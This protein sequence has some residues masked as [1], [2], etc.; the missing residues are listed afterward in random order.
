MISL[1]DLPLGPSPPPGL[2]I[3]VQLPEKR[4]AIPVP[5]DRASSPAVL[6]PLQRLYPSRV[7]LPLYR[8]SV[9]ITHRTVVPGL[10][11]VGSA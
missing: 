6:S 8:P 10:G 1:L 3:T 4:S 11:R 9:K 2:F 5:L 7:P